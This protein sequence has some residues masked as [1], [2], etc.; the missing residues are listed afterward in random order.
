MYQLP[1][2]FQP[3]GIFAAGGA[4]VPTQEKKKLGSQEM[5]KLQ[6]NLK[7]EHRHNVMPN[8]QSKNK[9]LATEQGNFAKSVI[10]LST[11]VL[12]FKFRK[13]VL[14]CFVR[15]CRFS[16]TVTA[17][18][19]LINFSNAQGMRFV[20]QLIQLKNFIYYVLFYMFDY[21]FF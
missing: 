10:K 3:H 17:L 9:N 5:R 2:A 15:N 8:L 14:R 19:Q 13:L 7:T 11:K 4:F 12:F 6:E 16:T 18:K 20:I 21:F 1:Y